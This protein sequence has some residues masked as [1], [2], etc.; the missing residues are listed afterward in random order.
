MQNNREIYTYSSRIFTI[1]FKQFLINKVKNTVNDSVFTNEIIT[2]HFQSQDLFSNHR[3]QLIN[4][5]ISIYINI[6]FY[7]IARENNEKFN[8]LRKKFTKLI[9]FAHE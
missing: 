9:L 7:H 6:R 5:I 2:R 8:K 3:S 1:N 4:L